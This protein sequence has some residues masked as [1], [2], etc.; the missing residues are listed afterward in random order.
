MHIE[1]LVREYLDQAEV[2]QL[3]TVANNQPWACTVHFICTDDFKIYWISDA[4]RRHSQE[5]AKNPQVAVAIAVKVDQ[6]V[7][8]VQIEGD[9]AQI[10]DVAERERA[11]RQF[12]KRH[13]HGDDLIQKII[14]GEQPLYRL[15]PRLIAIFDKQNFPDQPKQEWHIAA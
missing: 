3:A 13:G 1:P 4:D 15:T 11:A 12:A 10:A 6:P 14:G 9:A 7:I 8:G 5:I 2:M